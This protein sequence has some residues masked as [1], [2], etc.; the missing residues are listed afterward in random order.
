MYFNEHVPPHFHANYNEYHSSISIETLGIIEGDLPSK[1][2]SIVVEWAMEHKAELM[3][4][5]EML[6]STGEFIKIKPLV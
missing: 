6:R 2:Y 1:V 4:N 3:K 5:W